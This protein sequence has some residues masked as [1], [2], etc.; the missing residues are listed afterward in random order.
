MRALLIPVAEDW[1][2]V[3]LGGVWMV[4]AEPRVTRV[5]SAPA[6]VLGLT[7]VR[8]E[9]VPVLDTGALIG[10][11]PLRSCPHVAV[12]RLGPGPVALGA[13]AVPVVETLGEELGPSQLR[14][15]TARRRAEVGPVTVLDLADTLAGIAR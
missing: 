2:A 8:G 9:V 15:G 5:P 1:Y 6:V 12:L 10:I 4:L 14:S 7:N 3:P 11:T 13:S